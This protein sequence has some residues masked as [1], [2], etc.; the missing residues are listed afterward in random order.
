MFFSRL[1]CELGCNTIKFN[2]DYYKKSFILKQNV[3]VHEIWMWDDDTMKHN[4][5]SNRQ[6][7][8]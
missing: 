5:L 2:D 7:R 8:L 4:L 6:L 3:E 1:S